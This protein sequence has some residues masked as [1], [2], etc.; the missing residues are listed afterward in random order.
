MPFFL[1][2]FQAAG[3]VVSAWNYSQQQ[4]V[5]QL[6]RK[7]E[8]AQFQTNMEIVK[9]ESEQA[10]VN[11]M[12]QV[13]QNITSQMANNNARGNRGGS[14]YLGIAKSYGAFN[15]DER[16]RRMN[17]LAKQ[18]ELRSA[19]IISGLHTLQSETQLGQQLTK[20]VLNTLP[21]TSAW[22]SLLNDQTKAAGKKAASSAAVRAPGT[23]FTWGI[24]GG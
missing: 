15:E 11:E 19:N 23:E 13:R 8:D 9:T 20:D 14:S 2:A 24:T 18:S 3:L 21:T 7:L 17:L 4:D 5:I 12:K 6:G 1:L 16:T 22:D 10:S